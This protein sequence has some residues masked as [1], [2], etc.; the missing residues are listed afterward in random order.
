MSEISKTCS[1]ES[2][3]SRQKD[4]LYILPHIEKGRRL[5]I[6][7]YKTLTKILAMD[8][9]EQT[10]TEWTLPILFVLEK[11][12]RL[13]FSVNNG[14]IERHDDLGAV[15]ILH[16]DKFMQSIKDA[17]IFSNLD[18]NTIYWTV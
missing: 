4:D 14:K 18:V 12:G 7:K 5:E 11:D 17:T 2:S 16:M 10:H 15:V 9:I 3:S 1:T 13:S 8:A 6:S